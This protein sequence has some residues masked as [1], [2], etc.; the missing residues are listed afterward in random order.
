MNGISTPG[1]KHRVPCARQT[2]IRQSLW[3]NPE[4]RSA[5][6]SAGQND[7]KAQKR[8]EYDRRISNELLEPVV[9]ALKEIRYE[10]SKQ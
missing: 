3:D 10:L 7:Q 6:K 9:T 5:F 1:H 8:A 4:L 2:H